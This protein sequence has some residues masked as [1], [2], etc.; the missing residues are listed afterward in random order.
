M[1]TKRKWNL[2]KTMLFLLRLFKRGKNTTKRLAVTFW[3]NS[4]PSIGKKLRKLMKSTDVRI[5]CTNKSRI[6]T[7]HAKTIVKKQTFGRSKKAIGYAWPT[8]RCAARRRADWWS[9]YTRRSRHLYVRGRRV[10]TWNVLGTFREV[11]N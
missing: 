8:Y 1:I 6:R 9:W 11:I 10:H 2:F 3:E 5:H 4:H 7:M